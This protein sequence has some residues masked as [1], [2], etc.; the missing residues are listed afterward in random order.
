MIGLSAV[1]DL[2][3]RLAEFWMVKNVP[4]LVWD[5]IGSELPTLL[6][7]CSR[8]CDDRETRFVLAMIVIAGRVDHDC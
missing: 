4:A 8:V 6:I 5:Q 2:P 3:R 1:C 7:W